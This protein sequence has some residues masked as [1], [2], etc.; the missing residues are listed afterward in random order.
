ML[1]SVDVLTH[2][3]AVQSE[4]EGPSEAPG[5]GVV[6]TLG[7]GEEVRGQ[8][9]SELCF[10]C[11]A[12]PG[13]LRPALSGV[14]EGHFLSLSGCQDPCYQVRLAFVMKLVALLTARKLPHTYNVILFLV[15]H[16][17]EADLINRVSRV[18]S[19]SAFSECL[20]GQGVCVVRVAYD[21]QT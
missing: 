5:S 14:Y 13:E 20:A 12:D 16:D 7:H 21:A 9:Q 3:C 4:V 11:V 6:V 10:A 15:I 17:P 2:G 19:V 8:Y 1:V 18:L